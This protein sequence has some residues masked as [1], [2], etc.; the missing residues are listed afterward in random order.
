MLSI[1]GDSSR[2]GRL[3]CSDHRTYE[4]R[5]R[6]CDHA[7]LKCRWRARLT[8]TVTLECF[9]SKGSPFGRLV[10]SGRAPGWIALRQA[11]DQPW[12]GRIFSSWRRSV[13][14]FTDGS[15]ESTLP[16]S[17]RPCVVLRSSAKR[18]PVLRPLRSGHESLTGQG[19]ADARRAHAEAGGDGRGRQSP[20]KPGDKLD[21]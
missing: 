10:R 12:I 3:A 20:L 18:T 19:P 1:A 21:T 9:A 2:V 4:A 8:R 6:A 11:S 5:L 14:V 13:L 16:S 17:R 7:S 15:L